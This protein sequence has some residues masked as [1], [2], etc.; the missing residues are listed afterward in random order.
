MGNSVSAMVMRMKVTIP[1]GNFRQTLV[2]YAD[3]Y[4]QNEQMSVWRVLVIQVTIPV[5]RLPEGEH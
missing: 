3:L 2:Y 1:K 5:D 4:G